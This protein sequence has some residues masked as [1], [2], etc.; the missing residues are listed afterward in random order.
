[1]IEPPR[2]LP[3]AKIVARVRDRYRM[4]VDDATF[5]PLGND[6]S[7]WSFRLDG[8]GDRWFLKVFGRPVDPAAVEVPRFLAAS[9]VHHLIPAITTAGGAPYD[10][11]VPFS[12]VLLPFVDAH[13][14]GET[15]L[16]GEQRM[17]LGRLLRQIHDTE[18]TDELAAMMRREGFAVRDETYIER[19]AAGLDEAAPPD[20]IA[21]AL[22]QTWRH[23]RDAIAHALRRARELAAYGR[24]APR[25]PVICH[26][27]F[28]AW[29]ILIE[30]SGSLY[31]VDWD[32]VVLAPRERDLMFVSGDIADIDPAG[33]DFYDGY[34]EVSIDR[35]LIAYYRYDWVLQE[36]ADY[37]RRVFDRALGEETRAEALRYFVELF[38]PGDVVAAANRADDEIR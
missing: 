18:P 10:A 38:G 7:A 8:G 2:D 21:A 22:M 28:H 31:V 30:P 17:E 12:F 5:L 35:A 9:G 16:T 23:Q 15:G 26:A 25:T 14:G 37:H 19:V 4:D 32:E 34:G 27:D 33:E 36:V 29:N 1:M 3:V 13:P 20:A 24:S 11:G 6:S